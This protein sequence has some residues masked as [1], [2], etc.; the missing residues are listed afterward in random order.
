MFTVNLVIRN[1]MS[2]GSGGGSDV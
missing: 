1:G 2:G